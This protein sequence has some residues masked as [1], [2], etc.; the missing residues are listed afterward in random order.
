MTAFEGFLQDLSEFRGGDDSE[1][2]VVGIL[3]KVP[4]VGA[5]LVLDP[6]E[7]RSCTTVRMSL[8]SCVAKTGTLAGTWKGSRAAQVQGQQSSAQQLQGIFVL[9]LLGIVPT[10]THVVRKKYRSFTPT[11][12]TLCGWRT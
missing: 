9:V 1:I 3:F 4:D 11:R 2:V 8:M 5:N 10:P 7:C 6:A 12:M